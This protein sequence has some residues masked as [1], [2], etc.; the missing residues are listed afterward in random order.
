[1]SLVASC[2]GVQVGEGGIITVTV[3][4]LA[5]ACLFLKLNQYLEQNHVIDKTEV[6]P[7]HHQEPVIGGKTS[8]EGINDSNDPLI[9]HRQSRTGHRCKCGANP[10]VEDTDSHDQPQKYGL[11]LSDFDGDEARLSKQHD[12]KAFSVW[13]GIALDSIPE[14]LV[15]GFLAKDASMSAGFLAG[16]FLSNFPEALASGGLMKRMG[17]KTWK[18]IGL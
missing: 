3:F 8:S 18:I 6:H 16:I 13:L 12:A 15:I 7:E 11:E 4:A 17:M 1:M 9:H 10:N 5:G 14:S 2:D